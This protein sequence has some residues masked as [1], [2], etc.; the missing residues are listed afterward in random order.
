MC[1][2]SAPQCELDLEAVAYSY[3]YFEKLVLMVSVAQ[4]VM[5]ICH[6]NVVIYH[7]ER[8]TKQTEK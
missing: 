6:S 4:T 2:L 5:V 7:R 3:V 1:V 8:S